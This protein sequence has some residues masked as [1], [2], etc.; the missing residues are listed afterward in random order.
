MLVKLATL[1]LILSVL[2]GSNMGAVLSLI[3]LFAV[4]LGT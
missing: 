1:S 4:V 3:G 2:L